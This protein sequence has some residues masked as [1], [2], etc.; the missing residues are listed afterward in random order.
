MILDLGACGCD[1]R[2]VEHGEDSAVDA[3][4]DGLDGEEACGEDAGKGRFPLELASETMQSIH[5]W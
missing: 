5:N 1:S 4:V 3:L 2:R